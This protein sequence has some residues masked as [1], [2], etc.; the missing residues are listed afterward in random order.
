MRSFGVEEELLLVDADSGAP[1]AHAEAVTAGDDDTTPET[2]L[3]RE[4]IETGTTPCTTLG[5]LAGQIRS[6]RRAAAEAAER[7][8]SRAVALAT[9][10]VAVTPSATPGDRYLRMT[11]QYA[12]TAQEQ[13][14]CGCHV[15]VSTSSE[16]EGVGILDRIRPWLPPLLAM[17]A[18][19]PFWQENDSGYASYRHQV[20]GRWPS[21]GPTDLFG[22]PKTY[23]ETVRTMI[24]SGALL[25]EGMVYF[26][27][28]ISRSYPTV[29][30][31]VAD[32][33]DGRRR[34]AARGARTRPGGH[35]RA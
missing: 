20:W 10:P 17:T 29:E 11:E 12:L 8:G 19:S 34:A 13:L 35:R 22:T 27:A 4:Q 23:H 30:I 3:K 18:N 28:R 7:N 9:S 32:V 1:I 5:E 31:R 16:E 15:H 25:D 21:A 6:R 26:D 2:E 24:E 14:T 33:S